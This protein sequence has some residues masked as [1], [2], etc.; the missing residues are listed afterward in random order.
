MTFD[1]SPEAF[2]GNLAR[3]SVHPESAKRF[4]PF[5]MFELSGDLIEPDPDLLGGA[6]P[7]ALL[8]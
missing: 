8:Q 1:M 6:F 3:P 4:A 5:Q 7:V 2:R